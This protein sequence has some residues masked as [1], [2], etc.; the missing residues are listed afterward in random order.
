M[1]ERHHIIFKS[2][3]G[4]DFPLNY[5]YLSPKDHRGDNSPHMNR[6]VDLKYK[7][8]LESNLRAILTDKHY[9]EVEVIQLLG[10]DSKQADK[11]FRHVKIT[12]KGMNTEEVIKR[13]LGGRFYL[14]V[15]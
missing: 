12:S 15:D 8:E 9:F 10:L 14:G 11:A 7:K 13:L 2:A 1:L 5:K 6:E 4:I 3:G